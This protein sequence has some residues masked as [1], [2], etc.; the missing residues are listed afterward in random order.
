MRRAP[1]RKNYHHGDLRAQILL[2]SA[3]IIATEGIEALSIRQVAKS[4]GVSHNAPSRHF[5]SRAALIQELV[6]DILGRQRQLL[7]GV[8]ELNASQSER[9]RLREALRA[10]LLWCDAHPVE[11]QV[12]HHP[13]VRKM[14]DKRIQEAM[15]DWAHTVESLLGHGRDE[16]DTISSSALHFFSLTLGGGAILLNPLLRGVTAEADGQQL[17]DRLV[18]EAYP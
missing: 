18:D 10:Y 11:A 14:A 7:M 12:M 17:I 8:L 1:E 5:D 16:R 4:L 15:R 9:T 2:K 13:D 6:L 3:E